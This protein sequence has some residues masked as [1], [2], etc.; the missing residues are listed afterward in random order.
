M[1][2]LYINLSNKILYLGLTDLNA[3]LLL[4]LMI[5]TFRRETASRMYKRLKQAFFYSF[6]YIKF[7]YFN[8]MIKLWITK[9]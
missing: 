6:K 1:F 2:T 3:I 4:Y 7:I 8:L 5:L 9:I